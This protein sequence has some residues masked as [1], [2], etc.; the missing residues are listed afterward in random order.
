MK[1][2]VPSWHGEMMLVFGRLA[3][4]VEIEISKEDVGELRV[5]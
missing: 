5:M 4:V 1:A 3:C 2:A